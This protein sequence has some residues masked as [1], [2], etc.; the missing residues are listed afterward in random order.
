MSEMTNATLKQEL[1]RAGWRLLHV[2][3]QKFPFYPTFEEQ[4]KLEQFIY[5]FASL[6]PCGDWY[7][8]VFT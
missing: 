4:E 3:A 5:M 2:M 1:G 8:L 6:Y 7:E